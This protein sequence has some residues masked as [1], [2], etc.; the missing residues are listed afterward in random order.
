M[1]RVERCR[2]LEGSGPLRRDRYRGLARRFDPLPTRS[3]V[4]EILDWVGRLHLGLWTGYERRMRVDGAG[5][6]S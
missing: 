2:M 4:N 5:R 1:R 6:R 3:Q